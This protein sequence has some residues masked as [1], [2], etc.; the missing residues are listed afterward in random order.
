MPKSKPPY[1]DEF[2]REAV[3]L[4]RQGRSIPD[5]AESLGMSAQSL[6]SWV[7]QEQLD[8]RE[9]DDGLT[10]AEREELRPL[11][12][13]VKR[14]EQERGILNRA[15]LS[16]G[17]RP[18]PGDCVPDISAERAHC[19][20]LVSLMCELLGV[21]ESRYWAWVS[22]PP[23]DRGLSDAWLTERIRQLH[24]ASGGPYSSPRVHAMLRR[25]GIRVGEKRV[26]RLMRLAGL[27]GAHRRRRKGCTIRVPG[28]EPFTDLVGRN[29]RPTAPNLPLRGCV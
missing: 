28:V 11:R 2:R 17:G 27:Q 21:S 6:R 13:Q 19:D 5:V 1:P 15:R 14:L 4:D 18:R 10:S 3:E 23:S 16:S 9:R 25:E 20:H 7:R 26:E 24:S 22:R 12:K 8:R 29:F